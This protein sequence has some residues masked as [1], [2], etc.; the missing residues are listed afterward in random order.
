MFSS[1]DDSQCTTNIIYIYMISMDFP[2][3]V[4]HQTIQFRVSS[5][6]MSFENVI[7][8]MFVCLMAYQP[9]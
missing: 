8:K 9:L 6:S 3:T 4:L 2:E 5:V 7:S 1:I